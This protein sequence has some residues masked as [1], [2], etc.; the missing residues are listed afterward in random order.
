MSRTRTRLT[1]AQIEDILDR[2]LAGQKPAE[3]AAA[4]GKEKCTID[5]AIYRAR[6]AGDPRAAFLPQDVRSA[7]LQEGQRRRYGG[8]VPLEHR[9]LY[10]KLREAGI[11]RSVA[12]AEV[13][14]GVAS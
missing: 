13:V 7:R 1:D 12:F 6:R 5:S 3:I 9:L 10:R 14:R 11:P 8:V 2:R 4:L